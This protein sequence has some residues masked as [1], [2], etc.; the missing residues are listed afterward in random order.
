M[1]NQENTGNNN[2]SGLRKWAPLIVL[3]LALAIIVLDTTILNVSLRTIIGDLHTDIQSIQWVITAYSLMLAAFTIT[4]GRLG[5]LFGRK[6]MFVVGAIIFAVGSFITSISKSVGV[7]ILGEAIIEGIGATLM[8]PATAS[9]LVS[10]YKGRDRQIGFG[11]WGGI[12]A[13][14]AAFGPVFGG[15][16]TTAYSWRW[17]FRINV[18]VA[19]ILVVSS[20]VIKEY[21]DRE[22]KPSIDFVGVI[23]SALGMLSMVFGFIKAEDYGWW[24]SKQDLVIASH[25][26]HLGGISATPI[27]VAIGL[28]ILTLFMV[29]EFR[30]Q[31]SGK[32]PLVS[33]KIFKNT[34]FS[35]GAAI[36]AIIMLGLAGISFTLPVFFQAVKSLDALHTGL[37]MLPMSLT[38]LVSAPLSAYLAKYLSPKILIQAGLVLTA[39][40]FFV[41]S[42]TF[43]AD[44]S[45]WHIM[46]GLIIFG[47][48]MGSIFSQGN[49]ITLS[50]VPVQ[51]S[52]EASGISNTL[53]QL[54][55]TLGSAILGAVL[56]STISTHMAT[57]INASQI[58]PENAKAAINNSLVKESSNIEF[59]G[60]IGLLGNVPQ[61]ITNEINSI[62]KQAT[63][64]GN[65]QTAEYAIIFIALAFLMSFRLPGGMNI[66]HSGEAAES[67]RAFA[68]NPVEAS[69]V[70]ESAPQG[71]AAETAGAAVA[72]AEI[73]E[74]KPVQQ[75][76]A[77]SG[78]N[79]H[80]AP[81]RPRQ[82]QIAG[83]VL[84]ALI[85]AAI[86]AGAGYKIGKDKGAKQANNQNQAQQ[87]QQDQGQAA[88]AQGNRNNTGGPGA[89]TTQPAPAP[90]AQTPKPAPQTAKKP[91]TKTPKVLGAN[92]GGT[93]NVQP[94]D[95]AVSTH[96]YTNQL[97]GFSVQIPDDWRVSQSSDEIIFTAPDHTAYSIQLYSVTVNT[98][99]N[100]IASQ[101]QK[102]P[103]VSNVS[104]AAL[105]G[106]PAV[107]FSIEGNFKQGYALVANGRLY[108][109][110]GS[111]SG[112][113]LSSFRIN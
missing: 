21:M 98:D 5:D 96:L 9:L 14:S 17:A 65:R 4:G 8:L 64:D 102:Q 19:A 93:T 107:A 104:F 113:K 62:A 56:I 53:R 43:N 23:L 49:N 40:G 79:F 109:V 95:G 37:A 75:R 70:P 57:G 44:G 31:K 2:V 52:G 7:M 6:R 26:Y 54:G 13:A 41:L 89:N 63:I 38:L 3:S 83:P 32:T 91:P 30:V 18:V 84:F 67:P 46:P 34:Q 16:L 59:G 90:Q 85:L 15:W 29:W 71:A 27:F 74:I 73:A 92:T 69:A 101:L 66:E 111:D 105:G 48:G 1:D 100:F 55:S 88:V 112:T 97:M 94:R 45:Q 22:H 80:N 106:N 35:I 72:A 20:V 33:P 50:A 11:V 28:V 36:M 24:K 99:L 47:L 82:P 12:A 58:I 39:I 77:G 86:A 110:L 60:G 108:Y 68:D 81:Q 87:N 61:A 51:E 25:A 10:N 78:V 42:R 103:N 76:P